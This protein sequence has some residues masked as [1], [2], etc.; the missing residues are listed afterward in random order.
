[1]SR[2]Y[3]AVKGDNGRY[4]VKLAYSRELVTFPEKIPLEADTAEKLIADL[5]AMLADIK[6]GHVYTVVDGQLVKEDV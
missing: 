6:A 2:H 5:E 1:M 4:R 3:I